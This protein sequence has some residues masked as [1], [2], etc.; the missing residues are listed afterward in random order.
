MAVEIHELTAGYDHLPILQGINARFNT[1]RVCA[2][3]G[4]NGSGKTTL[5]RC[6]NAILKPYHGAVSL[7]GTDTVSLSRRQI[8][9][10]VSFVPQSSRMFFGFS[11]IEMIL[12][13]GVSRMKLWAVPSSKDRQQAELICEELGITHFAETA[14]NQLSGGQQQMVMVARA[15]YQD[16]S[17][18]L[19]DEPCSHLDFCNQHKVM[20]VIREMATARGIT[21]LVTLHD[22][23]LALSY[24]DDVLILKQ[25]RVAA[26]GLTAVTL[27]NA[28][29]Q[30]VFGDNINIDTTSQGM[31]VIVPRYVA[32]SNH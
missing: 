29:L 21:V 26:S 7:L 1:G 2:L 22:P 3:L 10:I 6:I 30:A 15:L 17:I 32:G 11:C 8:A 16:T 9:R 14:F 5:M 13:G 28:N 24:S 27:N 23:N 25:G 20:R 19:L 12:M 18:M 31:P 4:H